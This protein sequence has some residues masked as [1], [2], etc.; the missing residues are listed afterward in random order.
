MVVFPGGT[1]RW[2]DPGCLWRQG[3]R[4][5]LFGVRVPAS[6][7]QRRHC[8]R[9]IVPRKSPDGSQL[10]SGCVCQHTVL[11]GGGAILPAM[12]RS[13]GRRILPATIVCC[14]GLAGPLTQANAGPFSATRAVIA[15]LD[16]Q[17]FVGEAEGHL[18]GTGTIA[19]RSQRNP[20]LACL[21][22]FTSNAE[23]GGSGTLACSDG[24]AATFRFQRLSVYR[25]HGTGI[26]SRGAMSF[27]YGLSAEEASPHLQLP[28][29]K[30]FSAVGTE[31]TLVDR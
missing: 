28:G 9:Q 18:D 17:L 8:A 16:G 6:D 29:D 22:A 25:G 19:I 12:N 14:I 3:A 31:L 15:I 2:L 26:T 10:I 11:P 13:L 30:K 24:S 21:G 5:R 1:G 7:T 23:R 4:P 20:A 27:V